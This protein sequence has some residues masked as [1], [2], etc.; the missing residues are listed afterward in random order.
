MR[1]VTEMIA[2]LTSGGKVDDTEPACLCLLLRYPG[3][4]VLEEMIGS[5]PPQGGIVVIYF[6]FVLFS[7]NLMN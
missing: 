2:Y 7:N 6:T 5:S 1:L 3:E 4:A